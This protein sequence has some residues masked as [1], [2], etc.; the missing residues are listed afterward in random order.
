[1]NTESVTQTIERL[2][3]SKELEQILLD[4]SDEALYFYSLD[5]K[6]IYINAAFEKIT[7]YTKQELYEKN[8]I[9]FVHP[10]DQEW[11]MKLYEGLYEGEFFEDV[12]YRIIKKDGEIRWCLSTWKIVLDSYGE[13]I[14]IQGKQQDITKRK[15]NDEERERLTKSLEETEDELKVL[16]G[17]IPICSYCHSI[18]D[19]D[20]AWDR[21]ETYISNHSG[22]EFSHGICP[23]CVPKAMNEAKKN[24]IKDKK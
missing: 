18:R 9:P 24:N 12:E 4:N 16:K 10:G 3:N 20:G 2:K 13:Q 5:G 23:K 17:I 15:H 11:T 6:L 14:G 1:M 7:G 22:A 8:F 21:F 19:E